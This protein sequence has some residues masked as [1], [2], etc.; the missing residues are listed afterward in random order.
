MI[1]GI[2]L[3]MFSAPPP[4]CAGESMTVDLMRPHKWAH[5]SAGGTMGTLP[6]V[7]IEVV[8]H[9]EQWLWSACLDSRNGSGQGYKALAKW[10]KFAETKLEAA[11]MAADEVRAFMHRAT[12][13]EQGRIT[14]WLGDVLSTTDFTP[15]GKS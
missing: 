14:K 5:G 2:Q 6:L 3:D 8:P 9:C 11:Q 15:G 12:A 7:R 13:D 4:L 10:G 1:P